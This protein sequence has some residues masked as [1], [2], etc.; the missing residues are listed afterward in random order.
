MEAAD[1]LGAGYPVPR[2]PQ[3]SNRGVS[4]GEQI[5]QQWASVAVIVEFLQGL[6]LEGEQFAGTHEQALAFGGE[7]DA[8]GR[9]GEQADAKLLL[10][11]ADVAA[12]C[13]L[14]TYSRVAALRE[15]GAP[16]RPPRSDKKPWIQLFCHPLRHLT[17]S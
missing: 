12:D 16:R 15:V 9:A 5:D 6:V 7:C 11:P 14:P 10:E 17:R 13:L 1:Q 4:F 3:H 2:G 8:A